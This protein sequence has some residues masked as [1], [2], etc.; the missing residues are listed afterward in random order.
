MTERLHFHFSLSCIGEG[1]GNP[2]HC[3]CLENPRDR[4]AWWAAV[5]GVAQSRTRLKWLRNSSSSSIYLFLLSFPFP[6][7]NLAHFL[8]DSHAHQ[9]LKTNVLRQ[10]DKKY[11]EAVCCVKN[12][13]YFKGKLY[14]VYITPWFYGRYF[15]SDWEILSS[16]VEVQ[17][18]FLSCFLCEKIN[19]ASIYIFISIVMIYKDVWFF[20]ILSCPDYKICLI[21]LS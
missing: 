6:I 19:V 3:S 15:T 8:G 4:G 7:C 5:Y 17:L 13:L 11:R 16:L 1:N 18:I 20:K 12:N 10:M 2:L 9:N 14:T 21:L